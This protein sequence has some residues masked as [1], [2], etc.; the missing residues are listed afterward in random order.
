MLIAM[1]CYIFLNKL[2]KKYDLNKENKTF[3]WEIQHKISSNGDLYYIPGW[4]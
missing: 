3:H 2:Y 4:E 1:E